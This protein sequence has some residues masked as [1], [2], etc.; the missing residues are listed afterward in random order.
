MTQAKVEYLPRGQ[1]DQRKS[2]RERGLQ[3]RNLS[4]LLLDIRDYG[5][6]F[7]PKLPP[8]IEPAIAEPHGRRVHGM[9][10]RTALPP[11]QPPAARASRRWLGPTLALGLALCGMVAYMMA[12]LQL[13]IF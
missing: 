1:V 5:P 4:P 10:E 11:A 9:V 13:D 3:H 12:V 6:V 2:L 8:G 7:Q